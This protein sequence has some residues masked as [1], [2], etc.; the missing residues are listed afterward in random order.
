MKTQGEFNNSEVLNM[1]A[2]NTY[3]Y[4][5]VVKKKNTVSRF[6]RAVFEVIC[7]RICAIEIRTA[8][9]VFGFVLSLGVI[10]G[11]ESGILPIYIGLPV[12]FVLAVAGLLTHFE[13]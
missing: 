3:G 1:N 6:L 9:M 8:A 12:C 11:M 10:G 2:Y 5:R 13:D 4:R 7:E